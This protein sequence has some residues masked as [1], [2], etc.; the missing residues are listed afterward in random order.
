MSDALKRH[1]EVIE[2]FNADGTLEE[3]DGAYDAL[4]RDAVAIEQ[5]GTSE[6]VDAAYDI[7]AAVLLDALRDPVRE[8]GT[9]G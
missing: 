8:V 2:F 9:F 1:I 7:A 3:V 5:G 6:E 4:I